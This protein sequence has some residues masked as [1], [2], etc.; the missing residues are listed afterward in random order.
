MI[1]N[2]TNYF[3]LKLKCVNFCDNEIGMYL[4]VEVVEALVWRAL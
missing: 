3:I 2:T 4:Y 1:Y